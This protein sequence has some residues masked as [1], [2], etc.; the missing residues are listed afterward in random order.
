MRTMSFAAA[1]ELALPL[2]LLILVGYLLGRHAGWSPSIGEALSRFVFVVGIPSMLFGL[3][4]ELSRLPPIDGRVLVAYFGACLA[5]FVLARLTGARAFGQDGVAQSVF[6]MGA[7]YGNTV[8]IGL[9]VARAALGEEAVPSLALILV[10]NSI[11]LWTVATTS[12]EWARGGSPSPRAMLRTL[13]SV[14]AN[15]VVASILLGAAWSATGLALPTPLRSTLNLLAQSAV[16]LALVSVGFGLAAYRIREGIA[17]ASVMTALK[18]IAL[19]LGAWLIARAVGLGAVETQVVV[20]LTSVAT[21][22]NAYLM[23][24][25]FRALQGPVG[26]GLILSHLV[27]AV[28]VP[29]VLRLTHA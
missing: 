10:T 15:P 28:T 29:L 20:L 23:A 14:L 25:E 3:T 8:M 21:G 7:I 24:R 13:R 6:A 16:P 26:T 18:L 5:V 19:P 12:V 1:F 2:Y 27:S 11:V 17:E 22:V 9:P 4:S